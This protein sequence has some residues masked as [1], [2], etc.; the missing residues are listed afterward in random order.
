[1]FHVS[2]RRFYVALIA[3]LIFTCAAPDKNVTETGYLYGFSLV[4]ME[5]TRESQMLPSNRIVNTRSFPDPSDT[6]IVRPNRDTLYSIA[7]LDLTAGPVILSLPDTSGPDGRYYMITLLDAFTNVVAS[8][9]W[10]TTGK[11]AQT[12]TIAGPAFH[13]QVGGDDIKCPTNLVWL[14]GRTNVENT[15]D[16]RTSIKQMNKY[17]LET[18]S[19]EPSHYKTSPYADQM[20]LD[21]TS[22]LTP[23]QQVL[24]MSANDFFKEVSKMLVANPPATAD[25]PLMAELKE[26]GFAPGEFEWD[27]LTSVQQDNITS[28]QRQAKRVLFSQPA[29]PTI[30]GWTVPDPNMGQYGIDYEFRARTAMF[31]LGANL[32]ADAIYL[33]PTLL[34]ASTSYSLTFKN[35]SF[36]PCKAF[37]SLTMYDV[38]GYL[39][40]NSISRYNVGSQTDGLVTKSDGS[41][42]I[43]MQE[44]EPSNKDVNWLPTPQGSASAPTLR[45]YWPSNLTWIPPAL[46]VN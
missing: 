10:R 6:N 23:P 39:V 15:D 41:V 8:P 33:S 20:S 11:I 27:N 18:I 5:A 46:V 35:G 12:I 9:G 3:A 17:T 26:Y 44:D 40:E 36:P 1:M 28:G 25:A 4:L 45:C 43:V 16:I 42:E 13:A 32:N 7:W 37:W 19:N 14:L 2:I 22:L 30:N 21:M 38:Q 24:S 31:G 34:R 29:R